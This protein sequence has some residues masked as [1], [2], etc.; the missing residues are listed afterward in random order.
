M[1]P[2]TVLDFWFGDLTDGF[3]DAAHR[4]RWYAFDD[5][6]DRLI[7]DQ[8]AAALQTARAGELSGWQNTAP[9]RL[10]FI[11][12]TD[13]FC[14]Q[15]HRGTAQA[16]AGDELALS[17]AREGVE[18]GI[19]R[20]LDLNQR[21]FFYMP[22]EHSEALID[23]HTAVGLFTQLR[24]E[25]PAPYRHHTGTGLRHAQQHRDIIQRFGRFPHR[26]AL[27]DRVSTPE[28]LD[29]LGA[30]GRFGQDADA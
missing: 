19:D 26:N 13:Q 27:L 12:L 30:S 29:F 4:A 18:R 8:F 21:A 2:A 25:T 17:A 23:Q 6:F 16:F 24:D 10:A 3:S 14:R 20:G 1:N 28:E 7:R 5:A 11:L 22:F 15:I 9:G